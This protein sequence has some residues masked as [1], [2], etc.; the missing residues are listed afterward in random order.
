MEINKH[1]AFRSYSL[2]SGE[3]AI[4][5]NTISRNYTFL[6]GFSAELFGLLYSGSE[7]KI[8]D[9]C[10]SNNISAKDKDEFC[11]QLIDLEIF[12]NQ[13]IKKKK[14]TNLQTVNREN[15]EY[16]SKLND[17]IEEL[18]DNELFYSI[19]IDLTNKCNERC[20]HCYHPFDQYDYSKELSFNEITELIDEAYEL[21][22]FSVT[23]SGGESLLR[24]DFFD[25]VKYISDKGMLIT[26]FTNGMLLTEQNVKRLA[27]YRINVVSI[28]IYG[29]I[30]SV[31]DRITRV[32]GSF[33][34]TLKGIEQLKKYNLAFD[35][36]CMVLA[37]N[38]DR[39]MQIRNFC[40]NLNYGLKCT[41]DFTLCGKINGDCK[42]FEHRISTDKL[43]NIF[44]TDPE[45]YIG[46]KENFNRTPE[47]Y[48]CNAG[49]HGLYCSADG[50]IYPCVSFRLYLCDFRN[51]KNINCCQTLKRWQKTKI[52]DFQ[53]CF[54]HHYCTYC[55]EQC[56]G[57]N[58]IENKNY[59]NGETSHCDRA[60]IIAEWFEK[61]K[62][63]G[64][65][66]GKVEDHCCS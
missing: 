34:R 44:Y 18:C 59:L 38:A 55:V 19:H 7:S 56:A 57:N 13:E 3:R 52:S 58:L 45:Y 64:E 63:G 26:L 60:K 54:S 28:S 9:W 25:I 23:L 6:E 8:L 65:N 42:V 1:T 24:K 4:F 31:H 50:E 46:K 49:R 32:E 62:N 47:S 33:E 39:L 43:K 21:G 30:A 16:S 61:K 36:K 66:D 20:I 41:L 37:E 51:L 40:E 15:D 53:G 11:K 27:E 35:L 12:S 2:K 17:F 14:L 10:K 48:T 22:V 5:Y 29:D